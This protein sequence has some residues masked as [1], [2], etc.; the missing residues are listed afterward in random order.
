[1]TSKVV[2]I[3]VAA[4]FCL[5]LL[6]L[7]QTTPAPNAAS[8]ASAVPNAPSAASNTPAP[9]TLNGTKV[10][11][12][13]IELAI[14][15]TNEGQRDL[16]ALSKKL[17]PKQTELKSLND[18]I[19][20]LKKQLNDQGPKMNDDAA[21]NLR[22]QIEGKQKSFDRSVQDAREE[23]QSQQNEIMQRILQRMV[24]VIQTYVAQNGYGL[25]LDT[26]QPWPQ[27]PIVMSGPS[28]DITQA[29]IDAYNVKSGVPAPPPTSAGA[30]KPAARPATTPA[31]KPATTPPNKPATT[32]PP[33]Q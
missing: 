23:A 33:K 5:S 1:M 8:P 30:T 31:T 17:E 2:R 12:I 28:F 6:A 24:P 10:A 4:V 22:K 11:T 32:T 15:A 20:S 9:V 21:A 14:S 7:A 18:E 19:E 16:G 26:S 13:N 27:G 25:L 3:L 29:V